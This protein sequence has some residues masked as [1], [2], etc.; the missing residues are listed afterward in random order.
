MS[1]YHSFRKMENPWTGDLD[2][3]LFYCCPECDEK[4][5]NKDLFI[6]HAVTSHSK[7]KVIFLAYP[8]AHPFFSR[9]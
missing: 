1:I 4:S 2:K 6:G 5:E 3:Y 7:A 9:Y 8:R